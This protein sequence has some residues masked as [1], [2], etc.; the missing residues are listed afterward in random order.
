MGDLDVCVLVFF[1]P[2][3]NQDNERSAI[4]SKIDSIA[5]AE[6]NSAFNDAGTNSLRVRKITLFDPN[7]R[8]GNFCRRRRIESAEPLRK[9]TV[10]I[11]IN[12]L[13]ARDHG[14]W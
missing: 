1:C 11:R 5:G 13:P 4:F 14:K 7:Q 8:G 12:V 9:R 3:A 6:I 10:T 2:A